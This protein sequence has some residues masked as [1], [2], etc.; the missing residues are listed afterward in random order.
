L[1]AWAI[2]VWRRTGAARQGAG[3][4]GA[5]GSSRLNRRIRQTV[6]RSKR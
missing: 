1:L 3:A 4:G 5:G 2:V 6:Q